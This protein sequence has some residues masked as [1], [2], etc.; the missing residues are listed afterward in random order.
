MI[1]ERVFGTDPDF[2]AWLRRQNKELPSYSKNVGFVASDVD[3][4]L[5][6]YLTAVDGIGTRE[7]QALMMIEVKTRNGKPT[8]SQQDTLHKLNAVSCCSKTIGGKLIRNFGVSILILSGTDPDN[9]KTIQWGRFKQ[10]TGEVYY[11]EINLFQLFK[12]L[13]F[14]LHPDSLTNQPF[15]RHHKTAEIR[16]IEKVPLGFH[17]E[18]TIKQVS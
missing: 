4:I 2:C 7:I 12:L 16:V 18:R 1:R 3:L 8:P 5:H 9:S 11:R 10:V 17:V 15:R 14:E 13:K 6:R